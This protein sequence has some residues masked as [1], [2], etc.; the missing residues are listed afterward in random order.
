MKLL[1]RI[2]TAAGAVYWLGA[3]A[4]LQN[5]LYRVGLV[6]GHYRRITPPDSPA[7]DAAV[8]RLM[9][10]AADRPVRGV[11][12]LPEADTLRWLMEDGTAQ[13]QDEAR[14]IVD[15]KV[16]L[17]GAEPVPLDLNPHTP[18]VHWTRAQSLVSGDIKDIWESARFGWVYPLGRA[19]RLTGDERY[20]QAFWDGF[21]TFQRL[22]PYN[23]GPNW[24]SGQ[25][26]ALR[27]MAFGFA[28]QV[29]EGSSH[30]T[31]ERKLALA[32]SLYEHARRIPPTLPY[33]RS[34][35]NNHLVSEAVGLITV[36]WL[37][38]EL[39][40]SALWQK[41]GWRILNRALDEQIAGDG[42]YMQ[43]SVN[44]HRL[45]LE[46]AL[47]AYAIQQ[48]AGS[49]T[50]KSSNLSPIGYTQTAMRKLG[51]AAGWLA[52]QMDPISGACPNL[53]ANDG[54]HIL[55]LSSGGIGDYR[56]T[57]QAACLA[58]GGCEALQ[59]GPWDEQCHWL[60]ICLPETRGNGAWNDDHRL[61]NPQNWA[62]LRAVHFHARPSQADQLH[63]EIWRQ[64]VNIAVDAGTY[65]YNADLPWD[66][67]LAG[68]LVHNTVTVDGRDQMTRAGRFLWLDWAQAR[69][70]PKPGSQPALTAEHDG[71]ARSGILHQ[72]TIEQVNGQE[73][74]I[75]D[76]LL[77]S[78]GLA[79]PHL[80]TLHWLV[81][82]WTFTADENGSRIRL[83]SPVVLIDL[84]LNIE[85][86][87]A[88]SIQ[89]ADLSIHRA[90]EVIFGS[91]QANPV[92][93]WRSVTYSKLE[94]ALSIAFSV[95]TTAPL[96]LQTRW[97][98]I[99]E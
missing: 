72:R 3:P 19:Y 48:K 27:I 29:F 59:A 6:T 41:S 80:F 94:P 69:L 5:L 65:R 10:L 47:W 58:F 25:E 62:S 88:V 78:R 93:G 37:L 31:P 2:H 82:D 55:P 89:P 76:R 22:N 57:A 12:C 66:N 61:G 99:N 1:S 84:H 45:M 77:P 52:A 63:V 44:Y 15:G 67:A 26:A 13:V 90:G 40:E 46:D 87:P 7:G 96:H 75:T 20:S 9:Q 98:F 83:Q 28:W 30:S 17:Y 38:P 16:R 50:D 53:G 70:L 79:T 60:G 33:A 34:Q 11:L 43:Q 8:F 97:I 32:A 85:D 21:E 73:W 4:V 36:G 51:L 39:P 23:M 18:P 54:A 24:A 81:P 56:P 86:T 35:N 91:G 74:R 71:Y 42:T 95:T 14:E 49:G 92:L 64:G 68:T